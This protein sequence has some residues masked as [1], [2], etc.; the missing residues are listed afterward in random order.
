MR[1]RSEQLEQ[2]QRAADE[3]ERNALCDVIRRTQAETVVR[4]PSRS[5]RVS[6]LEHAELRALTDASMEIAK[7]F[8]LDPGADQSAFT[9]VRFSAAPN[10]HEHDVVEGILRQP[11]RTSAMKLKALWRDTTERHW[12]EIVQGYDTAAWLRKPNRGP[13]AR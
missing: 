4:L 9:A 1:I 7:S 5:C 10:F 11:G 6:E 12:D 2:F 3:T 13:H 8:G